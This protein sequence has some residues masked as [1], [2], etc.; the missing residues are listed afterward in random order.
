M[1]RLRVRRIK[2][3]EYRVEERWF[4]MFWADMFHS[5]FYKEEF[6]RDNV[7]D[8]GNTFFKKGAVEVKFWK[9]WH[10]KGTLAVYKGEEILMDLRS[11]TR[12]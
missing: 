4:G 1:A 6:A 12:F 7:I 5:P 11:F 3:N 8:W 10:R 9:F 2:E